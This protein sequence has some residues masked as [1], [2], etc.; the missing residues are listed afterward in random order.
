MKARILIIIICLCILG[1]VV[2]CFLLSINMH[3]IQIPEYHVP[4]SIWNNIRDTT[5]N[6]IEYESQ[7]N[8]WSQMDSAN[9]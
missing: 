1:I 5:L 4:D 9:N 6:I 7:Q 8:T 3:T 2:S